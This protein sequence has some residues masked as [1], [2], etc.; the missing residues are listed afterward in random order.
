VTV[1]DRDERAPVTV[2]VPD[3]DQVSA[4]RPEVVVLETKN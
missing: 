1:P 2:I 4:K 3:R